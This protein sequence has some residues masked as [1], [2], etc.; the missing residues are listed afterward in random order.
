MR[1]LASP[2]HLSLVKRGFFLK[3]FLLLLRLRHKFNQMEDIL[4]FSFYDKVLHNLTPFNYLQ[5]YPY[6]SSLAGKY[7]GRDKEYKHYVKVLL[8]FHKIT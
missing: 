6:N 5:Y 4:G 2:F 7:K 1:L 8:R 3:L